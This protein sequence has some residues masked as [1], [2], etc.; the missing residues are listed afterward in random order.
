[1]ITCHLLDGEFQTKTYCDFGEIARIT[2]NFRESLTIIPLDAL[3]EILD[4]LGK[5]ILKKSSVNSLPGV[6]YISLWLRREN[7]N[8]ICKVNYSD[9]AYLDRFLKNE[10]N[11]LMMAQPR[12]L[13]CHWIA[14]NMPTLGFF[15]V[16][17][18]ILS[19]NGSIVKM[20][21]EHVD[22][23]LGL[24]RELSSIT[25]DY[26]GMTYSGKSILDSIAVV[27]FTSRLLDINKNFSLIADCRI[28]FGGSDAV[29]AISRLPCRD[30]CE[31]IIF[32][33]KY[34]FIV[35]EKKYIESDKFKK[36]LDH[37]VKDV[38][39]FNQMACS[40][41]HVMFIE[42][43]RYST[44]VIALW[45]QD[46]FERLPP[47]LRIQ[48][49]SPGL[50]AKI[51]NSRARY[52]LSDGKNCLFP[53]DVGWTILIDYDVCLEEPIQGKC[54]FLKEIDTVD[55]V[56]PLVSHKIQAI[57]IGIEDPVVR[58]RFTKQVTYRG[59]DRIV[60]PG[61]IHDFSLP[62][63]GVLILNRLVRWVTLKNN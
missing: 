56:I 22:L 37:I 28:I 9:N 8:R 50:S 41:P 57:S 47:D 31:T 39:V 53:G 32:G 4:I 19:K 18:G 17:L 24:L 3:I 14:P 7:L 49:T 54:I 43:S 35:F 5:R 27:T 36:S 44:E 60:N 45:L 62:W 48:N 2:N 21:E 52:L 34:S 38:S 42:K 51:I 10:M 6:S 26:E 29:R 46:A 25:V 11:A 58:D 59:A 23:L 20:P 15:S 12:G 40:S 61:S 33:P 16:V 63:D 1:M 55:E 13:L 30:H